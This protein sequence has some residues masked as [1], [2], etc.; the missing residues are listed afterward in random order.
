[1]NFQ[2]IVK[3][4]S[5]ILGLSGA[6]CL[7]IV[8]GSG[9]EAIKMNASQ[10]D[11][12]AVSPLISIAQVTLFLTVGATL[13]FSLKALFANTEKLKKASIFIGIFLLIVGVAYISSSGVETPLKDGKF[14]SE[15]GSRWVETGIR[16]FYI[17]SISAILSMV[18]SGIKRLIR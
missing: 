7:F 13:I 1:M 12:S 14:L 18:F 17:L 8:M 5:A 15:S 11:F 3:V 16:T 10:G 4:L 6:I 2:F 9:D